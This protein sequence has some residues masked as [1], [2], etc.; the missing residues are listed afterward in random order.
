M[1][2]YRGPIYTELSIRNF[3]VSELEAIVAL[4]NDSG[5]DTNEKGTVTPHWNVLLATAELA[6]RGFTGGG[7][8]YVAPLRGISGYSGI[9]GTDA[10]TSGYS[11][12][13]GASGYSGISGVDGTS[14]YSGA[15]GDS[16]YSGISGYSGV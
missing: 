9:S 6:R 5:T 14:G 3:T 1:A 16:G 11:G 10:A 15:D 12:A 7:Y 4:A 8:P 2:I 13:D